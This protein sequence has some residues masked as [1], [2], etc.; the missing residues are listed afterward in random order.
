MQLTIECKK[1]IEGSKPN[2][3]R[4]EG[5]TPANLYGHKGS[6]SE[7]LTISTKDLDILLRKAQPGKTVVEVTIPE[8]DWAGMV[9]VQDVHKHPWKPFAYHVSFYADSNK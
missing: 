3:L 1:R 8:L 4:R 6:E 7:L 9:V 5:R 2:Q